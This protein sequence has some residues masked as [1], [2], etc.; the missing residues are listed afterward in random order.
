MLFRSDQPRQLARLLGY[1]FTFHRLLN[2]GIGGYGIG[3]ASRQKPSTIRRHL[4]PS[5]KEQRGLLELEFNSEIPFLV[6]CTHWGLD[7]VERK[8]QA[9]RCVEILSQVSLPFV[10]CGDLNASA[11]SEEV[12]LLRER[13][14]LLD[15]G[16]E[17][18][19]PTF[20]SNSPKERIDYIFC[21]SEWHLETSQVVS[22]LA[23]DHLPLFADFSRETI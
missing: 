19:Q 2:I 7:T 21:S 14:R 5:K 20:P 8:G 22:T 15:V 11:S 3:I 16:L 6:F 4:L 17:L 18:G 23:S 12:T 1:S 13:A 10:F 9:E